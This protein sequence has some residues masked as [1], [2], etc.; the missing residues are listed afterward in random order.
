MSLPGEFSLRTCT[1]IGTGR[2]DKTGACAYLSIVIMRSSP[3]NSFLAAQVLLEHKKHHVRDGLPVVKVIAEGVFRGFIPIN[4]HGINDGPGVYDDAAS[5]VA[6]KGNT[7]RI[8]RSRLS[9]FNFPGYQ[10]IRGQFLT[11]RFECPGK[12]SRT[13]EFPLS[14]LHTEMSCC[15]VHPVAASSGREAY[16]HP[17]MPSK[18]YS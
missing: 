5:R 10:V 18:G 3:G 1:G 9:A 15:S 13:N 6:W 4:H 11:A 7:R 8:R 17:S 12:P 2:T 14:Q 16:R